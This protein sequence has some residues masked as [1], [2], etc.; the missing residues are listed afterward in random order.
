MVTK[1]V[2]QRG[3]QHIQVFQA[4]SEKKGFYFKVFKMVTAD[5]MISE[6][7]FWWGWWD[8]ISLPDGSSWNDW[9]VLCDHLGLR[10]QL[11]IQAGGF[12]REPHILPRYK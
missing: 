1:V 10:E 11:Y 7:F 5:G 8:L 6:V 12:C 4:C 2:V 3:S 9:L